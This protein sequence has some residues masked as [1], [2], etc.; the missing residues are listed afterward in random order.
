MGHREYSLL[1][2]Q[3]LCQSG[4]GPVVAVGAR[5][6]KEKWLP[7]R[8]ASDAHVAPQTPIFA[9]A[10]ASEAIVSSGTAGFEHMLW[11][12]IPAAMG[13][14]LHLTVDGRSY[15][16]ESCATSATEGG[17][18][19]LVGGI[20]RASAVDAEVLARVV[21]IVTVNEA[22]ALATEYPSGGR[23]R[24]LRRCASHTSSLATYAVVETVVENSYLLIVR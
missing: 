21:D 17:R 9:T 6:P 15:V 14:S 5:A 10:V 20:K 23:F 3:V 22:C 1:Q 24:I 18:R 2:L 7:F 8:M 19:V 16:F 4:S 12:P 11:T 13:M